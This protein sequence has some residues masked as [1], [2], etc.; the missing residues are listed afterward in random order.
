ML[1]N[2]KITAP[3]FMLGRNKVEAGTVLS[4]VPPIARHIVKNGE[5]VYVKDDVEEV[6]T[7][8]TKVDDDLDELLGTD[9][10]PVKP[11]IKKKAKPKAKR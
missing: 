1:V 9:P 2:I 4:F 11:T 8:I 5:G 7:P 10:E 6:K 3:N